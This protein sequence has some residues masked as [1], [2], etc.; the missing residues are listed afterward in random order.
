VH[1]TY[2]TMVVGEDGQVQSFGDIYGHDRRVAAALAGRP[3]PLEPP[4]SSSTPAKQEVREPRRQRPY[5][6]NTNDIFSGLFG[7]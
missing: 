5:A 2:F 4:S 3:L 1:I 6:Q 7:N